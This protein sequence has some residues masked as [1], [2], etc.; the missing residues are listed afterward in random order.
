MPGMIYAQDK[1]D[2]IHVNLYVSSEAGFAVGGGR[3]RLAVTS[4]MPWPGR[5]R[6]ALGA[7]RPVMAASRLRI[8]GWA[9]GSP[10]PRGVSRV[11]DRDAAGR[12]AVNGPPSAAN[13]RPRGGSN[14][15][16]TGRE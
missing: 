16:D 4:E 2:A 11:A 10:Q 7:D 13:P 6:I 14:T 12:S 1:A 8:H 5:T 15:T 9:R 3:L